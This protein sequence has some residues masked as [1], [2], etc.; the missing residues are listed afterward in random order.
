MSTKRRSALNELPESVNLPVESA[1]RCAECTTVA[2][3]ITCD[4]AQV[5][6]TARFI[7][8]LRVQR[9]VLKILGEESSLGVERFSNLRGRLVIRLLESMGI[10]EA[11]LAVF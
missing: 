3:I 4:F 2:W 11:H 7:V 8:F 6:L 5:Q 1:N 10:Q 9:R